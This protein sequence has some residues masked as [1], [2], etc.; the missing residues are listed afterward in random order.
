MAA[1]FDR[2]TVTSI[3]LTWVD[4]HDLSLITA[5][6]GNFTEEAET[7]TASDI[8]PLGGHKPLESRRNHYMPLSGIPSI[9][10]GIV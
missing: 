5:I 10:P 1:S 4:L 9:F 2:H 6:K 7:M 8:D 3:V